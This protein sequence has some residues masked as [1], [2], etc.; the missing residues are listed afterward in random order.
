[1]VFSGIPKSNTSRY[2]MPMS[3]L[4][5]DPWIGSGVIGL[6]T[7]SSG[8]VRNLWVLECPSLFPHNFWFRAYSSCLFIFSDQQGRCQSSLRRF[9]VVRHVPNSHMP[10]SQKL[11]KNPWIGSDVIGLTTTSSGLVRGLWVLECWSVSSQFFIPSLLFTWPNHFS[12]T[13]TEGAKVPWGVLLLSGIPKNYTSRYADVPIGEGSLNWAG[14]DWLDNNLLGAYK[15]PLGTGVSVCF[16]FS[17]TNAP[18]FPK[19]FCCYQAFKRVTPRDMP[20]SLLVKDPWIGPGVIGLAA[21]SSGLIRD[22]WVLEC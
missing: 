17:Q 21:T 22:L 5:K 6:T 13:N 7:T 8:L 19:G 16:H 20:T 12:Q 9:V 4:V 15:G 2:N 3:L 14:C 11:V 18:K 1:L 10:M